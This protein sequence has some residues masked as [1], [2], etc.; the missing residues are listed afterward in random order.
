MSVRVESK[1][2]FTHVGKRQRKLSSEPL[3]ESVESGRIPRITRML[4]L[5]HRFDRLIREGTVVDQADLARLGHVSRA[6]VT[7]VLTLM[8][9]APDIQEAILFLP[10]IHDGRDVIQEHEIR[11]IAHTPDWKEQRKAWA[12]LVEAKF[13]TRKVARDAK[14]EISG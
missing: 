4:A 10:R 12:K 8:Q 3:E 11:P 13:P 2:H 5:A 6:R 9:L 7:Q 14:H 1:V